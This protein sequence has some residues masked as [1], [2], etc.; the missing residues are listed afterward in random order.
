[1]AAQEEDP[2]SLLNFYRALLRFRKE[3]PV[4]LWGDYVELLPEDKHLYVYERNYA[5]SKLLVICSFTAEQVRFDA[6]PG[7]RA[8]GEGR[9]S[10]AT[11]I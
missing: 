11:T 2:D 6:P 9:W 5:G 4:A 8:G 1:M 3:H 10:W 7:H